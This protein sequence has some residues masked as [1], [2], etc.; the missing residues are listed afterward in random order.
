MGE[1]EEAGFISAESAL[2]HGVHGGHGADQV[3]D[4]GRSKGS[5]VIARPRRWG[6]HLQRSVW[7]GNHCGLDVKQTRLGSE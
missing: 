2:I 7:S 4:R 1:I 5:W 6:P 3:R